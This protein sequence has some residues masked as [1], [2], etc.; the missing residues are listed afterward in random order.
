MQTFAEMIVRTQKHRAD[1]DHDLM[2]ASAVA[3]FLRPEVQRGDRRFA[4]SAA[5]RANH[6]GWRSLIHSAFAS[7]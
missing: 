4:L 1:Q 3:V 5:S 6:N 2:T 7:E